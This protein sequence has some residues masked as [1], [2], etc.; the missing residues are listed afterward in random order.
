MIFIKFLLIL[1]VTIGFIIFS[2]SSKL[3]IF[4]KLFIIIGYTV[5][6]F[7]ILYPSYSD[8]IAHIVS[9]KSGTDLIVYIV[10]SLT[11]LMNVILYVGQNN[12]SKVLTKIIREMAKKDA[13]KCQ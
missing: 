6:F 12:N 5:V 11:V 10:L 2:F 9:I 13:K 1:I 4:Q 8:E 3:K 7:F